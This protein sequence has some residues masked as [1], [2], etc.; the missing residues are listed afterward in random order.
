MKS[1]RA[2]ESRKRGSDDLQP[3]YGFDY[4]KA[5]PNRF[6]ARMADLPVVVVL[7][8]DVAEVF[9]TPEAV[10]KALRALIAAVPQKAEPGSR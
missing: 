8:P 4:R 7:E 5:K 9:S 6:A 2:A 10:H 3:E 1:T